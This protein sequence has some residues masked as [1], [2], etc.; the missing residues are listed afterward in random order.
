M[1]AKAGPNVGTPGNATHDFCG[2]SAAAPLVSGVAGLA[3]SAASGAPANTVEPVLVSTAKRGG[4]LSPGRC[5]TRIVDASASVNALL[6]N[7]PPD[8]DIRVT[9][10]TNV[11]RGTPITFAATASDPEG[12]PV[13]ISWFVGGDTSPSGTGTTFTPDLRARRFGAHTVRATVTDSTWTVGDSQ[14]G[15]SV[16]TFNTPPVMTI[17]TPVSGQ[18]INGG[19]LIQFC[20]TC[21]A[22]RLSATSADVNN[23]PASL[24]DGQVK[25]YLD[26]TDLGIGHAR[27]ITASTLGLG[28]HTFTVTGTDDTGL[29]GS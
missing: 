26:G 13:R 14:G 12:A 24:L 10:A 23:L 5:A 8:L 2:T 11:P 3:L 21:S 4:C 15:L 20:R 19:S 27:T 17:V 22:V 25:W 9:T 29:T 6:G 16:A 28:P 7:L 18:K 1:C